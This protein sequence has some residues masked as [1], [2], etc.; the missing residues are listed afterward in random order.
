MI[1]GHGFVAIHLW[2]YYGHALAMLRVVYSLEIV[3]RD[4]ASVLVF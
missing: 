1:E 2:S 4:V 3:R